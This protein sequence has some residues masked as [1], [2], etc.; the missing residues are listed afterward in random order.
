[1]EK[2][3]LTVVITHL[4]SVYRQRLCKFQ[5]LNM[6]PATCGLRDNDTSYSW[7]ERHTIIICSN[8][9]QRKLGNVLII[10]LAF[11]VHKETA[12]P[13]PDHPLS[14]LQSSKKGA[15][16][17]LVPTAKAY[18]DPFSQCIQF[19]ISCQINLPIY[20]EKHLESENE[21]YASRP[22]IKK[23]KMD[24]KVRRMFASI[25]PPCL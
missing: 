15:Y 3:N 4:N 6:I 1:M 23:T 24:V 13:T 18:L 19:S 22:L 5:P 25:N 21:K 8:Q 20:K 14:F 17:I 11:E 16:K 12:Y 10:I 9:L 2:K 7:S